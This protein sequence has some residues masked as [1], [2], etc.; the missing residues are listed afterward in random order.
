MELRR[1]EKKDF[2][3]NTDITMVRLAIDFQSCV[4]ILMLV[5][6]VSEG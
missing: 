2:S 5:R 3:Q 1:N 6:T 4:M